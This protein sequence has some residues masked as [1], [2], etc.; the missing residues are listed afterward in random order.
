MISKIPA[1]LDRVPLVLGQREHPVADTGTAGAAG[2]CP[3]EGDGQE[4]GV[5]KG[6]A[7]PVSGD[8]VPV[9][10]G[11]TDQRPPRPRLA[12]LVRLAEHAEHR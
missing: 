11:V 3:V 1:A 8:R 4:L 9:V 2:E 7:D 6:V 10:T 12:Q 5:A